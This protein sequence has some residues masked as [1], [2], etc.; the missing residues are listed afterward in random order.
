MEPQLRRALDRKALL[1]LLEEA[2]H[3]TLSLVEHLSDNDLTRQ[4]DPLMSPIVW[5]LGHIAH[6]EEVWLLENIDSEVTGSEGL[7]GVYNPVENPRAIRDGLRLPGR[8]DCLAYLARVRGAVVRSLE[9]LDVTAHTPLLREGFGFSLV[10]QHEYQH[11]ETILQTLQLMTGTPHAPV[12]IAVRS[13]G[14]P[15]RRAGDMVFFPGGT[16]VVGTDDRSRAYDNERPSGVLQADPFW[17]DRD[18]VTNGSFIEF[19]DDG[20]YANDSLWSD[21]GRAW[22]AGEQ[23]GAP[24]FWLFR[25]G[26]WW[27]RVMGRSTLL[28]RS[29]PVCHVCYYEAEAFSNWAGKRLPTEVEWEVAA[30]WD[31]GS[32]TARRF[33]WGDEAATTAHANLDSHRVSGRTSRHVRPQRIT[34]RMLRND[35]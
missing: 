15:S 2:R 5:D 29:L 21:E 17:I 34:A 8:A 33:S 7:R 18:P 6:F 27:T 20:G 22:R 14:Q 3:R 13:E 30:G 28:D 31:A 4:H 1:A 16:V 11:N 25:E 23:V 10:L 19:M 32:G 35:R 12:P 24:K 26:V 9:T